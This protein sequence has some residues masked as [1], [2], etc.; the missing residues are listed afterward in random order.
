MSYPEK[1]QCKWELIPSTQLNT[2]FIATYRLGLTAP[3]SQ[4]VKSELD[5]N[6][7]II[8]SFQI[9][10]DEPYIFN[11]T[12]RN[13]LGSITKLFPFIVENII[14]PDPPENVT[15]SHISG[16]RRKILLRWS[17]P[18]SWPFPEIF[19]LKYYI[20]YKRDG[21]KYK[22]IGPYEQN[23]FKLPVIRPNSIMQAQVAAKDFTD[24][25]HMSEWSMV[26]TGRL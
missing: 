19:P 1:L 17:P 12:A 25:G 16:E 11:V 14:R 18:H 26:V 13:P 21:L 10:A 22:M 8:S 7:C 5:P 9:F 15:L 24:S 2:T 3:H 20:L 23:Y 6:S 4:C